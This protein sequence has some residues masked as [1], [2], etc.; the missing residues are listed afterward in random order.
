MYMLFQPL[1]WV[2]GLLQSCHGNMMSI[3]L[4]QDDMHTYMYMYVYRYVPSTDSATVKSL[5]PSLPT[6]HTPLTPPTIALLSQHHLTR[7]TFPY[8]H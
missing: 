5:L 1:L 8:N 7:W 6:H 4:L 3:E 2:C